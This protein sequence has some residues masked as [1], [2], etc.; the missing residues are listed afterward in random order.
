M[1]TYI[2]GMEKLILE[3]RI[4]YIKRSFHEIYE[5]KCIFQNE[6]TNPSYQ[7]LFEW[8]F[9]VQAKAQCSKKIDKRKK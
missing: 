4:T 6:F 9:W 2:K 1:Y 8:G 3:P 7:Y 5:Q